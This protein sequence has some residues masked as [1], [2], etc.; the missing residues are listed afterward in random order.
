MRSNNARGDVIQLGKILKD[1]HLSIY[2]QLK[3]IIIEKIKNGDLRENEQLP[4]ESEL[5]QQ[6]GISKAPV[7]Q[8]LEELENERY[9]YKIRGKGSF[10][11]PNYIKQPLS[12]LKSF[13]E[14]IIELGRKPGAKLISKE[15]IKANGEVARSLNIN[16]GDLVLKAV[17]LRFIDDEI[18]SLNFSHF[19][20]DRFPQ[21][22]EMNLNSLSIYSVIEETL[23]CEIVRAIQ[24][25][26]ATA[27]PHDIA[28]IIGRKVGSP[29]LLM[30]RITFVRKDLKEMPME[31]VK[32][33]FM[34]DKYKFEIQLSK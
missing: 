31:F 14:D 30:N 18:F 34:P 2:Y 20:C 19:P 7:R 4:T 6:F 33:Y 5:S 27:T 28:E 21:L 22:D 16:E 11:S 32:V 29:L 26:E 15:I 13:T 1:S 25:L 3:Q 24:T 17:R 8:A 12:K 23:G 9:I 10:V